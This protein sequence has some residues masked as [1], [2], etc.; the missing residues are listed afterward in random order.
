LQFMKISAVHLLPADKKHGVLSLKDK[1]GVFEDR[2]C[3]VCGYNMSCSSDK[4][5]PTTSVLEVHFSHRRSDENWLGQNERTYSPPVTGRVLYVRDLK[6]SAR[7]LQLKVPLA[8]PRLML[9]LCPGLRT[10][11]LTKLNNLSRHFYKTVGR[12]CPSIQNLSVSHCRVFTRSQFDPEGECVSS[13]ANLEELNLYS[14]NV[15]IK[16]GAN[17][18]PD[19]FLSHI[20]G[21]LRTLT[22]QWNS[23]GPAFGDAAGTMRPKDMAEGLASLVSSA[24]IL[25]RLRASLDEPRAF[26]HVSTAAGGNIML[27]VI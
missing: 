21:R 25:R 13:W 10:L 24:P 16:T 1:L 12:V 5:V 27:E 14:V 8:Y 11:T 6:I 26:T 19:M 4:Q 3:K 23:P 18:K 20:K 15:E 2:L 22:V 9:S 7:Q 17:W